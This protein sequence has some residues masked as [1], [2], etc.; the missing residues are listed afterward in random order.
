MDGLILVF[1]L[2]SVA[3]AVL[4]IVLFFKVWRM[5]D[6]VLAIKKN[7]VSSGDDSINVSHLQRLIVL[8]KKEEAIE[9]LNSVLLND[10]LYIINTGNYY[11][12][13]LVEGKKVEL[14]GTDIALKSAQRAFNKLKYYYET[15]GAEMPE[16][17]TDEDK[18]SVAYNL[19]K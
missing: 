12:T 17:V 13:D 6:D 16:F 11:S 10:T 3:A 18:L 5:T 19:Q 1:A 9:Y 15:I 8:G 7:L 2:V 14:T 4:Q